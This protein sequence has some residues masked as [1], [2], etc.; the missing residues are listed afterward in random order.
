MEG[1]LKKYYAHKLCALLAELIT[2]PQLYD[3]NAAKKPTNLSINSDLLYKARSLKIN[4]SSTLEQ[5]L[6]EQVKLLEREKWLK[7]NQRAINEL[8]TLAEENGLFSDSFREF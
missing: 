3:R 4:L 8:N 2:M 1:L 7:E 5:A 6:G